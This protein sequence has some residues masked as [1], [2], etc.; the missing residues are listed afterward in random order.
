[1]KNNETHIIPK[2]RFEEIIEEDDDSADIEQ[3]LQL[4]KDKGV[5]TLK[6]RGL[7]T[8]KITKH[9]YIMEPEIPSYQSILEDTESKRPSDNK[10]KK[11]SEHNEKPENTKKEQKFSGPQSMK[12]AQEVVPE[13]ISSKKQIKIIKIKPSDS[14][15]LDLANKP[16][17]SPRTNLT[18]HLTKKCLPEPKNNWIQD[19]NSPEEN[20]EKQRILRPEPLKST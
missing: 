7:K 1:M 2:E 3:F 4:M 10:V 15:N 18:L 11:K 6:K 9:N 20:S 5:K 14:I 17:R 13:Y 8:A 19:K 16:S 12:V